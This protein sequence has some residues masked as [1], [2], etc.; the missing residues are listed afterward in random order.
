MVKSLKRLSVQSGRSSVNTLLQASK[1]KNG[2]NSFF[3]VKICSNWVKERACISLL[4]SKA[5]ISVVFE[6]FLCSGST[7]ARKLK[8]QWKIQVFDDI[9]KFLVT[10]SKV[11]F[12]H[13]R[14][15]KKTYY[16][17]QWMQL[18]RRFDYL[19]TYYSIKSIDM[20]SCRKSSKK[21]Y[22]FYNTS[23]WTSL[24]IPK[25]YWFMIWH[26]PDRKNY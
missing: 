8:Y 22:H 4:S 13:Y 14:R 11:E 25:Y 24:L 23:E 17:T 12:R 9:S 16:R 5:L 26:F 19:C 6:E 3:G 18:F 10:Y 1:A 15:R 7:C 20:Y 21:D 2:E